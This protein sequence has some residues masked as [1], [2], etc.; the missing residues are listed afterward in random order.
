MH[1]QYQQR[2]SDRNGPAPVADSTAGAVESRRL[3]VRRFTLVAQSGTTEILRGQQTKTWGF[4]GSILGPVIRARRGEKVGFTIVNRLLEPTTV[5]WHGMHVPAR[6]DGGPHQTIQPGDTWKPEWTVDQPG[7]TLWYHPHPHGSTE[8]H[9][10][11]GL[12][13]MFLIDDADTDATGLPATTA[14]TTSH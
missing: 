9:A 12:A 5:H 10:Y 4:N 14:S 13:G 6:F 1:L 11:R 2:Y 3:R 8:K 7:A